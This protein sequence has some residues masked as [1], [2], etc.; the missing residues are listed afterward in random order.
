MSESK[1]IHAFAPATPIFVV[2]YNE[3]DNTVFTN[4][5]VAITLMDDG[6]FRYL[7]YQSFW[8]DGTIECPDT[9]ANFLG[10]ALEE[11]PNIK[12]FAREIEILKDKSYVRS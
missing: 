6:E 12:D 2:L 4:P 1:L 8:Q 9:C 7:E 11:K 3:E 5:V 10:Y